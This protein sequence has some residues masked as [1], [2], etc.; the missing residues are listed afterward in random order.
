MLTEAFRAGKRAY[1]MGCGGSA[2]DAQ[3]FAGEMIGRFK[4]NRRALPLISLCTDTSTLTAI[5]NDFG[6]DTCFSKPV[7]ALVEPGDIVIGISTSGNSPAIVVAMELA[8][9]KGAKTVGFTG[10]SGGK[11]A[12]IAD[13][14]LRIPSTATPRVQE[15]H[16]TAIHVICDL[17][18]QA[19][20]G[21]PG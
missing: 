18:E 1:V 12:E 16:I 5:A 11:L 10:Q 13:I 14:C 15:C 9:E 19:L 7:E 3:H 6:F 17:V 8:K 4:L 20:F 2:A 21:K